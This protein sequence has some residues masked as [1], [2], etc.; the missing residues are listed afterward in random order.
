MEVEMLASLLGWWVGSIVFLAIWVMLETSP[1]R[2]LHA[3]KPGK[4][5]E[6]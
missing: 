6:K 1:E 4:P 5:K 2:A 3:V